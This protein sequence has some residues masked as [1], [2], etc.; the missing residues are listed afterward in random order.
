MRA[1]ETPTPRASKSPCAAHIVKIAEVVAD[2]DVVE[3]SAEPA[4]GHAQAVGAAEAAE[5]TATLHVRLQVQ[6]HAGDAAF[7]QLLRDDRDQL[8]KVAEHQVVAAVS[9]VGRHE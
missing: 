1:G 8:P 9:D 2:A 5:L 3:H 7:F 4:E 6:K